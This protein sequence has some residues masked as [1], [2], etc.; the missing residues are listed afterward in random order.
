MANKKYNPKRTHKPL[1]KYSHG[2][3][4]SGGDRWLYVAGQVG[5]NAKG[6]LA[7]GFKAQCDR[8]FRNVLAVLKDADMDTRD[9]VKTTVYL[10]RAEDIPAY[11]QVRDKQMGRARPAS[12]LVVIS[13]LA[14]PDLLVEIEAVAAKS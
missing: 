1:G 10:T 7:G 6:K 11:R 9:L 3:E 12:T 4:A 14:H 8:A 13:Q 2:I 5:I